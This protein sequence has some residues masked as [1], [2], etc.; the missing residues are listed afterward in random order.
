MT[1]NRL[2][3]QPMNGNFWFLF[4]NAINSNR[5][6][7]EKNTTLPGKTKVDCILFGLELDM[8]SIQK[9]KVKV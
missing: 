5:E 8:E 3:E 6:P 2:C 9:D 7:R 4:T 1:S